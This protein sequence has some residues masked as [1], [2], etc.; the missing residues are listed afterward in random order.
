MY[1][2]IFI[3]YYVLVIIYDVLFDRIEAKSLGGILEEHLYIYTYKHESL[4]SPEKYSK[5]VIIIC[6]FYVLFYY[7]LGFVDKISL[8]QHSILRINF[9]NY[10]ESIIANNYL[11]KCHPILAFDDFLI[12]RRRYDFEQFFPAHVTVIWS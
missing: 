2:K 11:E 6:Y 7:H 9:C 12:C 5:D 1:S 3:S 10:F 8:S 4:S